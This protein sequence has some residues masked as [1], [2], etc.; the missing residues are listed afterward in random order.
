MKN[1]KGFTL[2]ETLITIG[3][4]GVVAA[5]T[6][7]TMMSYY[8]KKVKSTRL[9]KFYSVYMQTI[10]RATEGGNISMSGEDILKSVANPDEMFEYVNTYYVPYVKFAHLSKT[11]V[12]VFA[13]FPDGSAMLIAK[14]GCTAGTACVH[15]LFCPENKDCTQTNVIDNKNLDNLGDGKNRFVFYTTGVPGYVY[16]WNEKGELTTTTTPNREDALRSC[17][18]HYRNCTKLLYI[19]NW[20]FK[21]DYPYKI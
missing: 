3:I 17:K 7:P 6:I 16:E 9:K 8:R 19:D 10:Y 14:S 5:L 1:K 2:A 15:I 11:K 21:N 4:I 12:G 20:E 13:G 18:N